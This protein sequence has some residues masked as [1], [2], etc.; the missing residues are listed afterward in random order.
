V[1]GSPSVAPTRPQERESG[2]PAAATVRAHTASL[3]KQIADGFRRNDLLTYASA[4]SFQILTAIVPF[5]LFV[6]ALAGLLHDHSAWRD[7]LAPQIRA[8]VPP[9][10]FSVIT[11]AVN[12]VFT[13][14]A[15]LWATLG[16]A[17]ALWQVSGAVRAVMGA[18]GRIYGAQSQRAFIK[19]YYI[20][21]VL[22][23][24]VGVS[25]VMV[26][27]CLL[28]APFLWNEHHDLGS[29]LLA[30]VVRWTL[31][32]ALLLFAVGVLVRHAPGRAQTLPWVS[33][34]AGIVIASWVLVSLGFS[35][36]LNDIA[37]YQSIFGGLAFLIVALAYLYISTIVFLFGT[38]LDAIIRTRATGSPWGH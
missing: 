28:F 15:V 7:H 21:F 38:Q 8:N 14:Q 27:A 37:S 35:F 5:L 34:G 13:H 25:F 11:N 33:L 3:V 19:R 16:G 12:R 29:E 4:I 24:E 17:L 23:I 10:I 32:I 2:Q 36:Y 1:L 26:G 18:L 31:V 22:S 20:S 30:G 9:A 6:F